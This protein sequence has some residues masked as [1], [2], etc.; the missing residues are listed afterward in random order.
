M[1]IEQKMWS[2]RAGWVPE[3]PGELNSKADLVFLF[4]AT[5]ILKDPKTFH[6]LKS[7]YPKAHILGCSTAGEICGTQVSDEAL[8][9]TA[10][11]F[12]MAT[13]KA[14]KI[15][16]KQGETSF[17]AGQRIIQSLD[18]Q[19]LVHVFLLSDGVH[20]NGSELVKGLVSLIPAG[21][22]ITG[23]LSGD[24]DRF[25]ETFVLG[26]DV[27]MPD[28]I[29]VVGLYGN[30]LKINCCSAGGWESFGPQR[31]VTRSKGNVLYELDNQSALALY[32]EYLG[33]YAQHLPAS[34]Q[35][36]PLSLQ[37]QNGEW[38]IRSVLAINEH[39]QSMIFAGDVPMGS[40]VRLMTA[41]PEGLIEGARNAAQGSIDQ[42]GTLPE[43]AILTTCVGR[44]MVLGQRV[45]E[46][47]EIVREVF[48]DKTVITGFY[49]YGEISPFIS[50]GCCE[51][52]NQTMAITTFAEV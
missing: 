1:R 44:K 42:D 19:D 15:Q 23:G 30:R 49:S 18:H 9:V 11:H 10:I 34:G 46:E 39:E 29:A 41:N 43:L 35:S 28:T 2:K 52:H 4:G 14:A 45:E 17:Q 38:V 25:Q 6:E 12:D 16:L 27:G 24:G 26:D 7:L 5:A 36:F 21:V 50:S 51:L 20:V 40:H 22:T 33:D 13:V 31:L 32:K 8:I 48:G 47:V 3:K 37:T